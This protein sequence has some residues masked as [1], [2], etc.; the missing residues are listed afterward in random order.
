MN[1]DPADR[2]SPRDRT[3]MARIRATESLEDVVGLTGAATEHDAYFAAK[4]EWS[5]L[6]EK[7]LATDPVRD[8]IPGNRVDVDG[9]RFFVHGITH[10]DTDQERSYLHDQVGR[11][12]E[13]GATVFCEQ[14]IRPMYFEKFDDVRAMDD[15]RWA[16]R[17][18]KRRDMDSHFDD[19][20]VSEFDGFSEDLYSLSTRLRDPVFSLIESGS[21]LY[22]EAFAAVLGDVAS[23]VLTSHET[24]ATGEDFASFSIS[25]AVARDPS[26][27]RELQHY[28]ERRFL[29]QP[30]E[31]EWLR[32][33][34]AELELVTH[35]RNER[36][37]E[38]AVY[39]ADD[40]GPVHLIVGAAHQPGVTYYLERVR[41]G[42]KGVEG[43][44]LVG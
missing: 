21:D 2:L 27:L 11:L 4:S 9:Q 42:K 5:R 3:W 26:R 6:R 29:P 32:R 1:R 17:E 39:H 41:D 44:E 28:Y 35:A 15:Y 31:R 19:V 33:H 8:G 25:R 36:M 16:I 18:C 34:D 12:L 30:I 24:M 38:Y 37:V 40:V 43:F 14:G 23:A 7:E 20:S 22:G 13:A 10:A